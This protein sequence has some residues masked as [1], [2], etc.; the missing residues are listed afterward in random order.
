MSLLDVTA[1]IDGVI[2]F[3]ANHTDFRNLEIGMGLFREKPLMISGNEQELAQV[4]I[5][6]MINACH[7][8]KKKGRI[9]MESKQTEDNQILITVK[10]NGTGIRKKD[11]SASDVAFVSGNGRMRFS[12]I[13]FAFFSISSAPNNLIAL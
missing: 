1:V 9:E 2:K 4:L 8:V 5:N 10:D 7:A 12:I 3:L 13:S 6:L 11:F